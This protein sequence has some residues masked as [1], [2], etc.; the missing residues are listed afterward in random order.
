[1]PRCTVVFCLAIGHFPLASAQE[2]TAPP[3]APPAME[4]VQPVPRRFP[5]F[6]DA[7]GCRWGLES[8]GSVVLS[9]GSVH[10]NLS[11]F[12]RAVSLNVDGQP[13]A[14]AQATASPDQSLVRLTGT[15]GKTGVVRDV[16]VDRQR[17][18]VRHA[19]TFLNPSDQAL[20]LTVRYLYHF[21]QPVP[22]IHRSDGAPLAE[23]ASG[24]RETS[25]AFI[26]TQP[27]GMTSALVI[28]GDPKSKISPQW[29]AKP[30]SEQHSLEWKLE[31]PAQGAATLLHWVVQR[32]TLA[33]EALKE[34][35]GDF[36]RGGR[37][38][39]PRLDAPAIAALVNFSDR[40]LSATD[41]AAESSQPG[42]LLF[43]LERLSEKLGI[44]PG[45]SDVY[46]MNAKSLLEG[47]TSGGP[48]A[49]VSRFGPLTVPLAEVA[50]VQGGG[51]RGRW[52]R[53]FF[54]DGHVLSGSVTLPDWKISGA[55]GWAI[56]L[57]PD[58]L[59][60][61]VLRAGAH[62]PPPGD[63]PNFLVQL[64]SGDTLP[65]RLNPEDSLPFIT[66]WGPLESPAGEI[67]SLWRLRQPA[68]A[69]RLA[70]R[71][72]TR[73]TVLPG[74]RDLSARSAR[75]GQISLQATDISALWPPAADAP[76]PEAS[77]E[78][79]TSLDDLEDSPSPRAL[80][81]GSSAV[82]A[83]L[84]TPSLSLYTGG[85]ET[86]LST[87]ELQSLERAEGGTETSPLFTV[88]LTSGATFQGAIRGNALA[89][90]VR[91]GSVWSVPISHFVAW[92]AATPVAPPTP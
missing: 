55:K 47:E 16:W 23:G 70:L 15:A 83:T 39:R 8:D 17:G 3:S 73:L 43:G 41:T 14:A 2:P 84:A 45:E 51:G 56:T 13:F 21:D 68:P 79:V 58:T 52:P 82:V 78:E 64:N 50:A 34:T 80:L 85:T 24:T 89:L 61:L 6:T 36:F 77:E 27:E 20:S 38:Q 65:L 31:V 60:A 46:Y 59:E 44:E 12:K 33:P 62:A 26:Q 37:L 63:A 18:G 19:D 49:L 22:A 86:E 7:N 81:Q 53:V 75:L 69:T 28:A 10:P 66:P 71:D 91:G 48:L 4:E 29:R 5:R 42:S 72:G 1:M 76:D 35:I 11:L 30:N 87:A 92:R 67:T 54:R 90:Q 74:A 25:L 32:P 40:G 88:T 57:N 9:G